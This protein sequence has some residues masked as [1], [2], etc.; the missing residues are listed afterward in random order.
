MQENGLDS[1]KINRLSTIIHRFAVDDIRESP[2]NFFTPNLDENQFLKMIS[3]VNDYLSQSVSERYGEFSGL[4]KILDFKNEID[5][6]SEL[7]EFFSEH[8]FSDEQKLAIS[9][10]FAVDDSV[11]RLNVIDESFLP[12]E[13][14]DYYD[15]LH[16]HLEASDVTIFLENRRKMA[17]EREKVSELTPKEKAFLDGD[18]MSFMV[19]SALENNLHEN[20]IS[21]F[22]GR[23]QNG[24][25][26]RRDLAVGLLGGQQNF[27]TTH[28]N[29]FTAEYGENSIT[30]RYGNAERQVSY[31]D[32]GDA[33]L[34]LIKSEYDDIVHDRKVETEKESPIHFGLLGNGITAYD[35]SRTDKET[36]DYPTVAHISPEG[37]V[38]IYDD[39][40]SAD[41]MARINNEARSVREKFMAEWDSLDTTTQLQRLYDRADTETMLNIG[42]ENLSTEEKIAKYM[43]FVFF[44]EG[45]RPKPEIEK[46]SDISENK[47][48]WFVHTS[49][50]ADGIKN[51][52]VGRKINPD[53]EISGRNME[54]CSG[55]FTDDNEQGFNIVFAQKMADLLNKNGIS[56]LHEAQN[57]IDN[58]IAERDDFSDIST[59]KIDISADSE[60]IQQ[61]VRDVEELQISDDK[62]YILEVSMTSDAFDEPYCIAKIDANGEFIDYY[63]DIDG[64]IP[65]F[66]TIAETLDYAKRYKLDVTNNL[67]EIPENLFYTLQDVIDKYFGTDCYSAETVDGAWKI[68]IADDDKVA[69]VLH[70]GE[71]I[72]SIYNRGDKMEIKPYG[73]STSSLK[74]IADAI[75]KHNP[76]KPVEIIDL[77]DDKH[78]DKPLF[79]DADV[80]EEIEKSENAS[81][82]RPF[83]E[84]PDIQGEQLSLFGDSVPFVA[85]KVPEQNKEVFADGLLVGNVNRFTALHDEIMRG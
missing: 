45:E 46:K 26:I 37:I 2:D 65:A 38:K 23:M 50:S 16:N 64:H 57:F 12:E 62:E 9:E 19:K 61:V 69:E 78:I 1:E 17:V 48:S 15:I 67:E 71:S 32:L 72:C 73:E 29:E 83:W 7:N 52:V 43:P 47:G 35:I 24:E 53:V 44:G 11:V 42:K 66:S 82:N 68:S 30:A 56:D 28:D 20:E 74:M 84:T 22:F 58:E 63:E 54:Y 21:E 70:D 31:E 6:K 10:M 80:I 13:I 79:S 36:N 40:I 60:S 4:N 18:I 77:I 55:L 51:G 3:L 27:I 81:D 34:S 5:R 41:D 8:N 75:L 14:Y 39:S 25:D 59:E 76:D 49:T 85:K 33:F